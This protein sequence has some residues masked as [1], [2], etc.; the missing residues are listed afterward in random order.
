MTDA[1]PSRAFVSLIG[2]GPGDPGLLTLRGQQALQEAD[3]V[4][5]DYLANPELLRYCS[6][7]RT[8]YVGKKGF[9]EYISQE[10]INTLIVQ[11]AQENGGQRVA[12]LKGGDVFVF[13]RG[14]EEAEACVQAGVPFEVVPGVSSAIAAPAYAGIPVTHRN[15]ARNFAV[16][17]GH[18]HDGGMPHETLAG[19]DTLVLLMGVRNLERIAAQLI[20]GGRDPATPAATVQWA[21]TPRQ[22]EVSGTLATIAQAVREAGLGAPAVTVVGEVVRLRETLQW[23][24]PASRPLSGRTV[25]VTRTREGASA[26]G[27]VLRTRG[28]EVLE[29]PLIR[30]APT[31][32]HD[33][34][35]ARLRDVNDVSW[36]LLTSNQAITALMEHLQALGLDARHLAGVRLAAVGPSTAAS[37]QQRGLRADFVPSTPG[38]RHLADELP[39]RPG[40]VALH[41]TSQLAEDSLQR[42]LEARG[43]VYQRAELYRTEVA[44]L[45]PVL[46]SRLRTVDAVTLASGSAARHLAALA[47]PEFDPLTL[48]VVAMGPQTAEAARQAGF[49]HLQVAETAS[50][51][52]LA[53]AVEHS[54]E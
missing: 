34:L 27:D 36:L 26:L 28:A 15:V 24:N 33:A 8:I 53:D 32:D 40:E 38:A 20:E 1:G 50:L 10:Q 7:A 46:R 14:G 30:F 29:V 39:V 9:S 5:F 25:A 2:A 13:G 19:V 21:S 47:G 31:S 48:R 45:D 18:T 23:F 41:L 37:L 52:A 6:Q 22:R 51:E 35:H 4:L 49:R 16:L 44:A 3:V 43:V 17:T 11:M 42:L 54:F 12:R